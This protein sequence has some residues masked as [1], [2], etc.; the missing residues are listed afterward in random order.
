MDTSLREGL[1]PNEKTQ[2]LADKWRHERNFWISAMC[3]LLWVVL[4]RMYV[5]CKH[6]IA[7]REQV[8]EIGHDPRTEDHDPRGG[9]AGMPGMVSSSKPDTKKAK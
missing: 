3:V 8:K 9:F 5:V 4:S 7:L 1:S 6:N 2:Q